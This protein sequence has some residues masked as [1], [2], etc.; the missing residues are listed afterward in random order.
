MP[1]DINVRHNLVIANLL[2]TQDF[3]VFSG[4]MTSRCQGL[5]S[6][7]SNFQGK[8]GNEVAG[9]GMIVYSLGWG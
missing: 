3:R 6:A 4:H 2:S 8:R 5:V 1:V 9:K 7:P